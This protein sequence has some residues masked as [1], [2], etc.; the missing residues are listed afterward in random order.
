MKWITYRQGDRLLTG[1]RLE[2]GVVP[3]AEASRLTGQAGW[4][5]LTVE[6]LV[7]GAGPGSKELAG[8]LRQEEDRLK[9]LLLPEE[10]LELG[11]C[12]PRP[13]KIICVGLNYRKHAVETG[14]P[15]PEFP[16]LFSKFGNAVAAS[17]QHVVL[18]EVSSMVDY[19]VELAMVIGKRA[20]QVEESE[21]LDYVFGYCTANDLSARD[22]QMRT[23]Q[24]L[25]GKSCDGFCPIGPYLV[26]A[27]EI[28]DPNALSLRTYVNGELRQNSHTSDMIFDCKTI[29]SY[30]SRH[31]TLEP[32]DLILTGTPEGVVMG[33]PK[34]RQVYLRDGDEVVVEVEGLGTL[35]NRMVSTGRS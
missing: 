7:G 13:G 11:P 6:E 17:G 4:A 16:V 1:L 25:L 19:E 28:P 32:G 12:L 3:W 21:A 9:E 30:I 23:S 26:T 33:Y 27:D 31:M 29:V 34:E 5:G 2:E 22:L 8:W 10:E 24:W 20:W 14:S 35:R 15:I 18:P